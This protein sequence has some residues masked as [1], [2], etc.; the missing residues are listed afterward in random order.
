MDVHPTIGL[1]PIVGFL[2]RLISVGKKKVW[3][4][5]DFGQR[6]IFGLKKILIK[7]KVFGLKKIFVRKKIMV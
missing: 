4:E 3:S 1:H 2:L 6:K 7:K 5:K